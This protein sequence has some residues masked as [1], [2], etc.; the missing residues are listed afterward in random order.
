M[1]I[2]RWLTSAF[3][4]AFSVLFLVGG[5]SFFQVT[6][7]SLNDAFDGHMRDQMM[8]VLT[9]IEQER[10][11]VHTHFTDRYAPEFRA[12]SPSKYFQIW[13][14]IPIDYEEG[15]RVMRSPSLMHEDLPL[16]QGSLEAPGFRDCLLKNG[17]TVR[18]IGLSYVP[19]VHDEEAD[20]D[21]QADLKVN[22]V[23]AEDRFRVDTAILALR[24][25]LFGFGFGALFLVGML[26]WGILKQGLTPL[27]E[28][29]QQADAI[30]PGTLQ[31]RF[32]ED[33]MPVELA[34]IC[35]RLN[36][37][38]DR[39][40]VTFAR[41][42]QFS[43]DIAHELRTPLAELRTLIEV[44]LRCQGNAAQPISR[45]TCEE[46]LEVVLQMQRMVSQLLTLAHSHRAEV[47]LQTENLT[48]GQLLSE[49]YATFESEARA[50]ELKMSIE[51]DRSVV[52]ESDRAL[53]QSIL[54]NLVSNAVAYA[55]EG[56]KI[57][58]DVSE[59]PLSIEITNEAPHL[60]EGDESQLF[61]RFWRK[62]SARSSSAHCGLGLSL[63]HRFA[64]QLGLELEALLV[65]G[66]LTMRL[67]KSDASHAAS[68]AV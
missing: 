4:L 58:V 54:T 60:K 40:S 7:G 48:V 68:A 8:A 23:L 66:K 28:V 5:S 55:P 51:G 57:A 21:R 17:Q 11:Y 62:D 35:R 3:L 2:K 9:L 42:R 29:S 37:L 16:I 1:S 41:E 27:R 26:S 34:P 63:C 50:K 32:P 67:F 13:S 38:L 53:F 15:P 52:W 61:A 47:E 25:H 12:E 49:V 22:V 46:A 56:S 24:N 45:A 18:A 64:E 14:P 10:L 30:A 59:S 33:G 6:K 39:L 44:E 31:Q 19:H 65:R 43:D 36:G 20:K